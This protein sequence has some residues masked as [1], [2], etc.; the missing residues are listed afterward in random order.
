[1]GHHRLKCLTRE[2][3][4]TS[5]L[6]LPALLTAPDSS[7]VHV[8]VSVNLQYPRDLQEQP[9]SCYQAVLPSFPS[10]L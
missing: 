4:K 10:L 7:G 5:V 1:M 6:A 9:W 8:T 2:A 3:S